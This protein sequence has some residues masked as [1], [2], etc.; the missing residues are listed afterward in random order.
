MDINSGETGG[1]LDVKEPGVTHYEILNADVQTLVDGTD[2]DLVTPS[3]LTLIDD[4]LFVSDYGTG[5]LHAFDLN[6]AHLDQYDTGLGPES[7]MGIYAS[8]IDDLWVVDA[9]GDAL[10]RLR[11]EEAEAGV[12]GKAGEYRNLRTD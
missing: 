1:W 5:I 7:L 2:F 6:G 10:Y 11:P 4:V 9:K 12:V 3:G 8:G